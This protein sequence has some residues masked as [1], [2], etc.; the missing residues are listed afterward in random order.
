MLGYVTNDGSWRAFCTFDRLCLIVG[1][2]SR[3]G[4]GRSVDLEIGG[5]EEMYG[6]E[7][8]GMYAQYEEWGLLQ[9]VI[10]KYDWSSG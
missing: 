2:M 9:D 10:R 5:G 4:G 3:W 1:A 6:W 7:C 8:V